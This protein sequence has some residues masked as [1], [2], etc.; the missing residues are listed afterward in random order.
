M[1][2]LLDR[3]ARQRRSQVRLRPARIEKREGYAHV[4]YSPS[5]HAPTPPDEEVHVNGGDLNGTPVNGT[6]SEPAIVRNATPD[7]AVAAARASALRAEEQPTT[8]LAAVPPA[9]P[10]ADMAPTLRTRGRIR[11]RARYLRRLR[12]IQLRDIGGLALELHRLGRRR[13]D[14]ISLKVLAAAETDRELRA[15]EHALAERSPMRE[16]REAGIGGA[17]ESCGAVHGSADHFCA[18][19]GEPLAR[20]SSETVPAEPEPDA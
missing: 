20:R 8:S 9:A 5:E 6:A 19:C 7:V 13:D 4:P 18:A 1:S 10:V 11:R 3:I 14:L 2:G 12:E 16:L 17:C 15:L